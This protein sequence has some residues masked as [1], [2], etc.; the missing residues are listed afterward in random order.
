[1]F[2]LQNQTEWNAIPL[3]LWSQA[4][5]LEKLG[6]K[7]TFQKKTRATK[8]KPTKTNRRTIVRKS[9]TTS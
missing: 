3:T 2:S 8:T 7:L 4:W 5:V 6:R 9:T 1:M